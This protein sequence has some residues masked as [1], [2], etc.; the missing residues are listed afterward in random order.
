MARRRW[1]N[2]NTTMRHFSPP[3]R[4]FLAVIMPLV[5][6]GVKADEAQTARWIHAVRE[7]R[8]VSILCERV[9]FDEKGEKPRD[10]K[11]HQFK[12]QSGA[13]FFRELG[14]YANAADYTQGR[15]VAAGYSGDSWWAVQAN[16]VFMASAPDRSQTTNALVWVF[17]DLARDLANELFC[18]GVRSITPASLVHAGSRRFQA[19]TWHDGWE[20]SGEV[21]DFSGAGQ[22]KRL[23]YVFSGPQGPS[24][25]N[26]IDYVFDPAVP[27]T[28]WPREIKAYRILGAQRVPQIFI[29]LHEVTHHA[30]PLP[31]EEFLPAVF[32]R[33]AP[34]RF[35]LVESPRGL[36]QREGDE[37]IQVKV[38]VAQTPAGT[39]LRF[40]YFLLVLV[41]GGTLL[42][43][44]LR[45]RRVPSEGSPL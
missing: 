22:P 10:I 38:A 16:D 20:V 5:A 32:A 19:P 15:F 39:K 36:F 44:L 28:G 21:L 17:A 11:K 8:P 6:I 45:R 26:Q 34:F 29:T 40:L 1:T 42:L 25:T 24:Q 37:L 41:A 4:L 2:E 14:D 30:R 31:E 9:I 3:P 35:E 7:E 18:W 27:E 43:V 12:R 13:L 23:Q 33:A